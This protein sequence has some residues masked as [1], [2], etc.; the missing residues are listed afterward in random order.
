MKYKL[1]LYLERGGRSSYCGHFGGGF[2]VLERVAVIPWEEVESLKRAV[3]GNEK[4]SRILERGGSIPSV[5]TY[6]TITEFKEE[7]GQVLYTV[8]NDKALK[9]A[10][11]IT[12]VLERCIE[13]RC[14]LYVRRRI[15][16][17]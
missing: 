14:S 5:E 12:K 10:R 13:E 4:L 15:E 2:K 3:K 8:C 11:T 17:G 6:E 16:E 7:L 1:V 9:A